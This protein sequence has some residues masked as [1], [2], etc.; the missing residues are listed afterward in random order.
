MESAGNV[1]TLLANVIVSEIGFS[2]EMIGRSRVRYCQEG[3]SL[4]IECEP[5][6]EPT[7]VIIYPDS[8]KGWDSPYSDYPLD[9]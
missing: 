3:R 1:F 8:I 4:A 6:L 9:K 5:A 7:G 2:V